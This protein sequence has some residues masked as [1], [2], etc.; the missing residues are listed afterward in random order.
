M[1]FLKYL[2]TRIFEYPRRILRPGNSRWYRVFVVGSKQKGWKK[3]NNHCEWNIKKGLAAYLLPLW[4]PHLPCAAKATPVACVPPS[5][6]N[7]SSVAILGELGKRET[8]RRRELSSR[9][10]CAARCVWRGAKM[11]GRR[12]WI[13]KKKKEFE[14]E[15][16]FFFFIRKGSRGVF[17]LESR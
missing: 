9:C 12:R 1:Q 16:I 4:K 15:S 7:S 14:E 6:Q 5:T 2:F 3:K 13:R 17:K 8:A 10:K 11:L